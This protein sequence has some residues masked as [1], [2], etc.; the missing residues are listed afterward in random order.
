MYI[1]KDL[2]SWDPSFPL[3]KEIAKVH[4]RVTV[5]FCFLFRKCGVLTEP[6][7][8]HIVEEEKELVGD[9]LLLC[10][11]DIIIKTALMGV[12][13]NYLCLCIPNICADRLNL[14]TG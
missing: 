5:I 14:R 13:D 7:W 11:C 8:M 10:N 3:P 4:H 2:L 12:A 6:K 9:L 1:Q